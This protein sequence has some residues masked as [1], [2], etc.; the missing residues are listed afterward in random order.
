[1]KTASLL[2]LLVSTNAVAA[3]V[4][5][6]RF[7]PIA[8]CIRAEEGPESVTQGNDA[9]KRSNNA[10]AGGKAKQESES[11][12]GILLGVALLLNVWSFTIPVELRRAN[13][14]S[15]DDTSSGCVTGSQWASSVGDHYKTCGLEGGADCVH[16]D[17]SIAGRE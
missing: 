17:F 5:P 6:R 3:F 14:C 10:W 15:S 16:F 4:A 8:S 7:A 9:P 1:M 11:R 2:A 13:I 12:G